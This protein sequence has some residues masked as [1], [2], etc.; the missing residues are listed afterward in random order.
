MHRV[1]VTVDGKVAHEVPLDREVVLGRKAPADLVVADG[2]IS[3][4]HLSLRPSPE[5]AVL[6]DLGSTNGTRVDAGDR[7]PPDVETTVRP[8]QKVLAGPAI[9]EIVEGG[10]PEPSDSGFGKTE[11]T[12]AVTGNAMQAVLVAIARFQAAKPRLVVSLEQGRKV[13]P[14]EEIESVIGRSGDEA[15]VVVDHQSVSS[16]H[17]KIRFADGQFHLSDLGSANGTFL[18]GVR[19]SGE[20]PLTPQSVVTLGTVD[21]LFSARQ[22]ETTGT[23]GAGDP[24]SD[25]LANHAVRLGKATPQQAREAV[26]EHRTSGR[27]LGEILVERGIFAP[28]EW[29]NL[30]KQRDLLRTLGS[31]A[32]APG[33][34]GSKIPWIVALVCA[35]TAAFLAWKLGLFG[36]S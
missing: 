12:V 11:K 29:S 20:S 8:G 28:K 3:T 4:R 32:P 35:C 36:K 25:L 23:Q 31:A 33:G 17:A 9:L 7:L 6:R 14:I 15:K 13:V 18:D 1:R 16:K 27:T 2:Q 34:G 5:G 26:A 10:G 22:P 30:W 24:D 21:C 19:I